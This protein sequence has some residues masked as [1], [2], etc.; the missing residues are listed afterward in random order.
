MSNEK[1]LEKEDRRHI[2][3][4]SIIIGVISIFARIWIIP[5]LLNSIVSDLNLYESF[6]LIAGIVIFPC[7]TLGFTINKTESPLL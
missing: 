7:T 5:A 1:N 6:L 3:K 2:Y 4:V